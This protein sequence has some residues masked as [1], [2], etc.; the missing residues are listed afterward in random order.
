M[1]GPD[2]PQYCDFLNYIDTLLALRMWEV[3]SFCTLTISQFQNLK[4]F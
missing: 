3:S 1:L 2:K 4:D